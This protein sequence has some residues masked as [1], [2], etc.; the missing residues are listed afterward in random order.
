MSEKFEW[1]VLENEQDLNESVS[2][3][4][5]T[6]VAIFKHSHKCFISKKVLNSVEENITDEM[7]KEFKFY[8][9]D[10]ITFRA[11]SNKISSQFDI[12]HES[13]QLIVIK[14]GKPIYS[15]SHNSINLSDIPLS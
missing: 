10:L 14:N 12:T 5:E 3:S 15:A 7:L 2:A 6:K 9:L 8:F 13:P 4:F 11:V 1:Q